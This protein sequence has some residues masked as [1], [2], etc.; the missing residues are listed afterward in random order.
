MRFYS[1]SLTDGTTGAP[2]LPSSLNTNALTT[3]GAFQPAASGP[4]QGMAITS[5][6]PN[7]QFNPAA[8][9]IEFDIPFV[10]FAAPVANALLRIWG[11]G[12]KD[13]GSALDLTPPNAPPVNIAINAGMSAGLPLANPKQQGL[14]LKGAIL[15]AWG[16]W[17]GT[18]QTLDFTFQAISGSTSD[19][20][21]FTFTW[22]AGTQLKGAI[23]QTLATAMPNQKQ[24]INI[25]PSLVLN[26]DEHGIYQSAQ[27]FATFI[28]GVSKDVIGGT[29]QGV[30]ISSDGVTVSVWDGT[31]RPAANAVK[32][33][34]FQDMLGQP[35]WLN[36]NTISVKLVLRGDLAI[37]DVISLPPSLAT[38]TQQSFL[39]FQDKSA[40][41]GNYI[42][43]QIQ[44]FGNFRQADAM[45]WNTTIQAALQPAGSQTQ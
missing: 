21:N 40:F 9:N 7:G 36:T 41:T 27:Q 22:P 18:E 11:L 10:N 6:L 26:H 31:V 34:A 42:V 43:Q 38:Q 19:P 4:G 39:R 12:L 3:P 44:H 16:N 32:A 5:L 13:I 2:I 24:V 37:S 8:L 29:Y 23:A 17:I 1:I 35:T 14:I 15:Q 25:S 20:L 30:Q 28:N 45:S 33:I